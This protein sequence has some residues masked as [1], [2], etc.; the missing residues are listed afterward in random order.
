[1][2]LKPHKK[3]RKGNL[4]VQGGMLKFIFM[5]VELFSNNFCSL[6]CRVGNKT[7]FPRN[8]KNWEEGANVRLMNDD[9]PFGVHIS[10]RHLEMCSLLMVCHR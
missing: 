5:Q 2:V 6:Q 4:Q 10:M 1:M 7:G 8:Y 9:P 3:I